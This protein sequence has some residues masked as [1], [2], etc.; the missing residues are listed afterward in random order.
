MKT[1]R[2]ASVGLFGVLSFIA[3]P[4]RADEA[5]YARILKERDAVLSELVTLRETGHA[6]GIY[7]EKALF[8]AR[9]ALW[10]FRRDAATSEAEKVKHQE[11]IVGLHEKELAALK[12]R[13]ASGVV[14]R[15]SVLLETDSL[16]QAQQALE[17]LRLKIKTAQ[18]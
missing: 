10:S 12:A 3:T 9:L 17:V 14:G 4:A 18:P 6:T 5:D 15:E 8:S 7:D 1:L 2:F 13:A 16:L 11:T